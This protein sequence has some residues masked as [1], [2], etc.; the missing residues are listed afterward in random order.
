M[1]RSSKGPSPAFLS[2]HGTIAQG[3]AFVDSCAAARSAGEETEKLE[4]K[5]WQEIRETVTYALQEEPAR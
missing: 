4:A 1:S 3:K 2:V 5:Q